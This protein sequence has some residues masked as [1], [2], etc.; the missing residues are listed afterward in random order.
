MNRSSAL[1]WVT[2]ALFRQMTIF[3]VEPSRDCR[4]A[5]ICFLPASVTTHVSMPDKDNARLSVLTAI[6]LVLYASLAIDPVFANTAIM[7]GAITLSKVGTAFWMACTRRG[8]IR[9]RHGQ[10]SASEHSCLHIQSC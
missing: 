8:L 9:T 3:M 7:A 4:A 5:L 2:A 6:L 1:A 10:L